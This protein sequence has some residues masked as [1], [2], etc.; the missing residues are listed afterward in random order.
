MFFNNGTMMF[1]DVFDLTYN[2]L[3][4]IGL[5]IRNGYIFDQDNTSGEPLQFQGRMIK[6]TVDRN[7]PCYAGQGEITFDILDNVRLVTTLLGYCIDKETALNGFSCLSHFIE[8]LP[9]DD[10]IRPTALSIKMPDYSTRST[11]YYYNKCL[12]YI[13][14]IFLIYEDNVDLSNFDFNESAK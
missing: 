6:A 11:K 1:D 7:I 14:A 4:E 9:T 3:T 10:I 12:K 13:H 2:L 5:N 8:E